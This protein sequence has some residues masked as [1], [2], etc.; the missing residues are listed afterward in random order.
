[1]LPGDDVPGVA[2]DTAA[3]AVPV[4]LDP[5]AAAV[6]LVVVVVFR[7][8]KPDLEVRVKILFLSDFNQP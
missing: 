7:I 1:M 8:G 2:A 4:E 6:A 5:E 3:A